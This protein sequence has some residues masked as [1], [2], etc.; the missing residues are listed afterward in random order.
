MSKTPNPTPMIKLAAK[1]PIANSLL[2][3]KCANLGLRAG[4]PVLMESTLCD[5]ELLIVESNLSRAA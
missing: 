3:M 4:S 5:F 1:E 2:A